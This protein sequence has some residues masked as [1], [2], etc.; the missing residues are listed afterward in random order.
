M[1]HQETSREAFLKFNHEAYAA[2]V[3]GYVM[4]GSF[5]DGVT[6]DEIEQIIEGKGLHQ[7]VSPALNRLMR[8]GMIKDSGGRRLTRSKRKAIVWVVTKTVWN[9]WKTWKGAYNE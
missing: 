1:E 3:L 2:K 4:Q 7:S 9:N 8:N 5:S 6:C